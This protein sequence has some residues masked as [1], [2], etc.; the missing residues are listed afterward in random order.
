M[1]SKSRRL[2]KCEI[3]DLLS[4]LRIDYAPDHLIGR[5]EQIKRLTHDIRASMKATTLEGHILYLYGQPGTGKSASVKHVVERLRE[6]PKLPKFAFSHINALGLGSLGGL[7]QQL[8][9]SVGLYGQANTVTLT[10]THA[11][12]VQIHT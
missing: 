4:F 11:H 7:F 1:A 9:K 3:S 2:A 12:V 8:H 10:H 6:D 5:D